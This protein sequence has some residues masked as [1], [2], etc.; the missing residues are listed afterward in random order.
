M[1]FLPDFTQLYPVKSWRQVILNAAGE[2]DK[3]TIIG[4][5]G[6]YSGHEE[7]GVLF[8]GGGDNLTICF[9]SNSRK[10]YYI[11]N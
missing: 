1:N 4:F 8:G 11:M 7:C 6:N 2:I 9:G 3:E 10:G 5:T